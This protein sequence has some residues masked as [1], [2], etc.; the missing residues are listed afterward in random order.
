MRL[1]SN[2]QNLPRRPSLASRRRGHRLRVRFFYICLQPS[3]TIMTKASSPSPAL[4]YVRGTVEMVTLSRPG[5]GA[6]LPTAN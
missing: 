4:R 1:R 6:M 3:G 5:A 2:L